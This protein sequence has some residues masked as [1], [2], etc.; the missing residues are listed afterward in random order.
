MPSLPS[1]RRVTEAGC[2]WNGIGRV[3]DP[4]VTRGVRGIHGD[5]SGDDLVDA[6]DDDVARTSALQGR[7]EVRQLS[8]RD[9]DLHA[10]RHRSP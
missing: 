10:E 7:D 8:A 6:A 4:G 3:T 5:S 2:R 1:S 9:G